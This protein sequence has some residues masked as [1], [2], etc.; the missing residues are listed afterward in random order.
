VESPLPDEAIPI[1]RFS[2]PVLG[3]LYV[4][5]ALNS[6]GA[7]VSVAAFHLEWLDHVPNTTSLLL[8]AMIVVTVLAHLVSLAGVVA[9]LTVGI[10]QTGDDWAVEILGRRFRGVGMG[11]FYLAC[12]VS[13]WIAHILFALFR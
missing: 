2:H 12:F 10:I 4:L 1:V 7:A 6:F 9:I 5:A 8:A 11:T 13:V 3:P